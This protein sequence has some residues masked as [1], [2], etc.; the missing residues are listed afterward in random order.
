MTRPLTLIGF[1]EAGACFAR[2][3]GWRGDARV[4]DKLTDAPATRDATLRHYDEA[5]VAGTDSLAEALTDADLII[6]LVTA[7]AALAV[8]DASASLIASGALF[9]DMNSVSPAT[10]RQAAAA[11]DAAGGHYVDVAVMAP[12]YP[13]G[14]AV[15]LLLSGRHGEE[16]AAR[17]AALGFADSR[18]VGAEI[19]RASAIKM[20]RSVMVKGLEA[21][22]TECATAADAAGVRAEVFASLDAGWRAGQSWEERAAYN[23]ERMLRHGGRRAAEM[24][25]V[26][27]TLDALSVASGMSRAT[28]ESQRDAG[29]LGAAASNRKQDRAA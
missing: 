5:E 2:A 27:K 17:L 19:G 10:K 7:D 3:G 9:C 8:A 28:R 12:V 11:I 22:T 29:R 1:G 26:V 15:P 16:A 20:I 18:P 4:Y 13:A 25:E 24:E 21:L 6:S 23:L 14:L